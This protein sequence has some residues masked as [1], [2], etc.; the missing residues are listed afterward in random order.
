MIDLISELILIP[1]F[2]DCAVIE[3]SQKSFVVCAA[4]AVALTVCQWLTKFLLKPRF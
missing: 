4:A 3:I 1:S 2:T